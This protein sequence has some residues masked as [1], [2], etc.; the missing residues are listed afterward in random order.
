MWGY[1][2][3]WYASVVRLTDKGRRAILTTWNRGWTNCTRLWS[4]FWLLERLCVWLCRYWFVL[5]NSCFQDRRLRFARAANIGVKD[6]QD[7]A[8]KLTTI[9]F[10]WAL[11]LISE[12]RRIRWV[13]SSAYFILG[14]WSF[15]L[16][17]VLDQANDLRSLW[18]RILWF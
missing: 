1:L 13:H 18:A 10:F 6:C 12:Q 15:E 5:R 11:D 3:S 16:Q 2:A 14:A 9:W 4:N 7:E 8:T 17:R